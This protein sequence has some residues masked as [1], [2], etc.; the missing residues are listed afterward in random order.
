MAASGSFAALGVV[1]AE[2]PLLFPERGVQVVHVIQSVRLVVAGVYYRVS[3]LPP[4]LRWTLHL[5]PA[6]YVLEGMREALLSGKP[7]LA[8]LPTARYQ[9]SSPPA[10]L[11]A[12]A[13]RYVTPVLSALS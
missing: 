9:P 10:T 1:V 3:V 5:S 11:R 6:T 8:L 13:Q 12:G 2:L 7:T 4:V